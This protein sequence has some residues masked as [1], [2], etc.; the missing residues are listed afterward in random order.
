MKETDIQREIAD[1]EDKILQQVQQHLFENVFN[2]DVEKL[3]DDEIEQRR[4]T[5]ND[6]TVDILNKIYRSDNLAKQIVKTIEQGS[7]IDMSQ[8]ENVPSNR[9]I[10]KDVIDGVKGVLKNRTNI[11]GT[12]IIGASVS[13]AAYTGNPEH[14]ILGVIAVGIVKLGVAG[15]RYIH[16][17][18]DLYY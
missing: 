3:S 6:I 5:V 7:Q 12:S 1:N 2:N 8:F 18:G 15:D 9:I 17:Q 13:S 16:E 11:A 10:N 4:E 14:A